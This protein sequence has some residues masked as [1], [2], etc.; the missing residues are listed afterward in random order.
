MMKLLLWVLL[1]FVVAGLAFWSIVTEGPQNPFLVFVAVVV[2]AV[3]PIGAF[4]MMYMAIRYETHPLPMVLMG[5]YSLGKPVGENL[6]SAT[7]AP[8]LVNGV[9][10]STTQRSCHQ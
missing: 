1:G 8:I 9:A 5:L 2:F 10:G 3:P 6:L 4:W 7:D